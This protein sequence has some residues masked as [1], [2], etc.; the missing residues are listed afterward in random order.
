MSE[1]ETRSLTPV[2]IDER[3][4]THTGLERVQAI[5]DGKIRVPYHD[6]NKIVFKE[7]AEGLLV[8]ELEPEWEVHGGSLGKVHGGVHAGLCDA[9]A[10][11]G[12]YTTLEAGQW[13]VMGDLTVH[14][15]HAIYPEDGVLIARGMLR[16]QQGSSGLMEAT[17]MQDGVLKAHAIATTLIK[18]AP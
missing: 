5:I 3:S 14:F 4:Q 6:T 2:E 7:A 15:R 1:A 18:R 11:Y 8:A 12:F 9:V 10:G 17:V 13:C 16:D